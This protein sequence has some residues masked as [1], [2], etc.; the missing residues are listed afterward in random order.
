LTFTSM[1]EAFRKDL[2]AGTASEE[3]A[4]D[5]PVPGLFSLLLRT[6]DPDSFLHALRAT[7]DRHRM[8]LVGIEHED[9]DEGDFGA[10]PKLVRLPQAIGLLELVKKIHPAQKAELIRTVFGGRM[11]PL[12][13]ELSGLT[14]NVAFYKLAPGR[15]S[16]M[17]EIVESL[18]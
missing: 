13:E 9:L 3:L 4:A 6:G 7:A 11:P 1:N 18:P 2:L 12:I 10:E 14:K 8:S 17:V 5:T 16:A 15:L